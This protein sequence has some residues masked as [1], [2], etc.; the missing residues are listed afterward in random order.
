MG[1]LVWQDMPSGDRYI[2]AS[3][4]DIRRSAQS[5]ANFENEWR[6][7]VADF[8]H[9]P[10]IVMWVPFNEGW[11]QYD[12]A[13]IAELT[14]SLDPTRLVNSVSGWADRG[15]GDVHDVHIYPGPGMPR[16][17]SHRAAVLGEFGGLG[18]PLEGHTWQSKDNWGY[19]SYTTQEA[20]N[21]AYLQLVERLRPLIA[22]GLAAAVYTQTTDVEI[23]VNGFMTYDREVLKFDLEKAAAAH[24]RLYL[25][26]PTVKVIAPTSQEKAQVYRYTTAKPADGWEKPEFDAKA[27]A[28]APGGFGERTTPGSVVRT[29]WKSSDIWVR[30]TVALG[31][32]DRSGVQL[33]IHHDEDSEVYINGVLA[34]R[35]VGYTSDYTLVPLTADGQKAL[36]AGENVIAIHT[37][38]T[39]GGQ[40]ID[41]GLIRIEEADAQTP[42]AAQPAA[43]ATN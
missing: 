34:A 23:E 13:R 38:Q 29:P 26:P 1:L 37:R 33:M 3:Q 19:R 7:I 41:F 21:T 42:K 15:V 17:E 2:S 36:K 9:F 30:R 10:S 11:G 22:S 6:E 32:G 14:K 16:V 18:L 24:A 39:R 28:E 43:G 8:G 31:E 35:L 27:W 5:A 20:L 4:P 12:T 25:P 40:Y